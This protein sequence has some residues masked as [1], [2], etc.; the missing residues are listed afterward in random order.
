M[1]IFEKLCW[2]FEIIV[3]DI[4]KTLGFPQKS[5]KIALKNSGNELKKKLAEKKD[6]EGLAGDPAIFV[7]R[8][9]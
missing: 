2:K 4:N 9:K 7:C 8:K 1:W 5:V 6:A 3:S